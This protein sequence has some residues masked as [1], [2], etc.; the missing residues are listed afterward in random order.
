MRI[1]CSN[2]FIITNTENVVS[3]QLLV[4]LSTIFEAELKTK[5]LYKS[6]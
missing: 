6:T 1:Q 4:L 3:S 2:K 5:I